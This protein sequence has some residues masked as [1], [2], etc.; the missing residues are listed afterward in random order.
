[1]L[2]LLPYF[3]LVIGDGDGAMYSGYGKI[4]VAGILPMTC[5]NFGG[6]GEISILPSSVII[7]P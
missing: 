5:G 4:L 2:S 1:L 6:R 7:Y 3:H